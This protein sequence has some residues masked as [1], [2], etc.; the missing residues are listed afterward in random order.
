MKLQNDKND[1]YS[2]E[3]LALLPASISG[4]QVQKKNKSRFS[5]FI[6]DEFLIGVSDAVLTRFNIYKG[7]EITPSLFHQILEAEDKWAAREYMFR[8]LSRR[9]HSRKELKTKAYK[10][11]FSGDFVDEILDELEQ[12]EYIDDFKFAFKYASDKFEFNEWGPYKIKT[13]LFKKGISNK[14]IEAV[15]NKTFEKDKINE[16]LEKLV[17]KKKKR[18]QR[19]PAE[20]RRK[21]V[22]DFLMRKGYDSS[23]I[24]KHMD[25]L[26]DSIET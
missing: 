15:I 17:L 1:R 16:N 22:F 24:L 11:G 9:D 10:K 19:V 3:A 7:V 14:V 20:K 6:E 5:L 8:I 26:L 12:K 13:E 2:E 25:E 18:F 21:K 4:I 23:S